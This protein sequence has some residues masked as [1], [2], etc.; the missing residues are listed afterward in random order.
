MAAEFSPSVAMQANAL[1]RGP[2]LQRAERS[3]AEGKV[4]VQW[5]PRPEK[6]L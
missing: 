5:D 6:A 2:E 1:T 3:A 4:A